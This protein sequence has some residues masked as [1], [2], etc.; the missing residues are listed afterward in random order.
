MNQREAKFL[1]WAILTR[2]NLTNLQPEIQQVSIT[3]VD[4]H[5]ISNHW[6][7]MSLT[8]LVKYN[9]WNDGQTSINWKTTTGGETKT[10]KRKLKYVQM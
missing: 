7:P 6:Q 3:F 9:L 1:G 2:Q 8:K 5:T 4:Y 10:M